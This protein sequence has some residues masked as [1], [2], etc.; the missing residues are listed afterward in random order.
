MK[1]N[2]EAVVLIEQD[3]MYTWKYATSIKSSP[4]KR[5]RRGLLEPTEKTLMFTIE[6]ETSEDGT[7][8]KKR[9]LG[10]NIIDFS[11][12]KLKTLVFKFVAARTIGVARNLLE[13][14]VKKGI[15]HIHSTDPQTWKKLPMLRE[16]N[17]P[18]D[19]SLSI[20]ILIHGTFSSTVGGFGAL[21]GTPWGGDFWKLPSKTMMQ[22]LVMTIQH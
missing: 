19:K 15:V 7:K 9:G 3:G 13:K 17:L 8:Q 6:L 5:K 4:S 2:E 22:S 12:G 21:G 10:D 16:L 11:L 18:L 20:L 1:S 14:N